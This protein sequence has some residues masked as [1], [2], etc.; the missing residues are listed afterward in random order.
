[1]HATLARFA[2]ATLVAPTIG[3]LLAPCALAQPA[4]PLEP[5]PPPFDACHLAFE[6][7]IGCGKA[8]AFDAAIAAGFTPAQ[9]SPAGGLAPRG[10]SGPTDPTNVLHNNLAIEILSVTPSGNNGT[11]E[12]S[13]SNTMTIVSNVNNLTTFTFGLRCQYTV[14]SCTVTDTVGAYA[15]TPTTLSCPVS[16]YLRTITFARPINAGET[17]TISIAY[18]GTAIPNVGLGSFFAG[19]Q[20]AV[21]TAPTV[22]ATLSEPYYAA[23]WWPCKDGDVYSLGDNS[24][25]ATLDVAITAADT[26]QSVSNGLLVGVDT[27]PGNRKTYRWHCSSP[28]SSYLVFFATSQYN[29]WSLPYNYGAGTM[30]VQFSIYPSSDTPTNRAVWEKTPA[31]LDAFAPI[32]G[33]Y[34]FLSEKYGVYQFEFS[35]G[36]EHQTYTGQGRGGAFNESIT[37]H[38]LAH[39]W[40]GDNITCKTWSDIWLNEG[41]ATYSECLWEERK[42]GS[43]GLGSL[44]SCMN[45]GNHRPTNA[46]L[47]ASNSYVYIP[48]A[49]I[50]GLS[51]SPGRIFSSSYSYRKPAWVL[52]A[53]RHVIG[54]ADFFNALQTY[55][56]AFQGSAATPADFTAIVSAVAGQDLSWFFTPWLYQPG[57]PNYTYAWTNTAINGQAYLRLSI[58]QTQ[59]S[60]APLFPMPVDVRITTTSSGTINTIVQNRSAL[61]DFLIPLPSPAA[62][63]G[64]SIDPDDWILNTGKTTGSYV[65]GPPKI[66]TLAPA[67]GESVASFA[68]P[69]TLSV[70]FSDPVAVTAADFGVTSNATSIPFTFAY[71]AGTMTATLTFA[72]PL[73]A[74][75]Y[76]VAVSDAISAVANSARL[77]GEL[78]SNSPAALPSGNGVALGS[79][80][81]TFTITAPC[82]ADFNN[83]GSLSVDDIFDFLNA[84]FAGNPAADFNGGGLAVQDIFDFLNAWFAGC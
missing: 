84:W 44:R 25:K 1:M 39:Q 23:T 16:S 36:Q 43:S 68:A 34:P 40:W 69:S 47:A 81:F 8:T 15:T 65:Q 70:G 76:N 32:Y 50:I 27:L 63:S 26:L 11:A 75:T 45:L 83:S 9:L 5:P 57:A 33:L 2:L 38:E 48:A 46:A 73:A 30:P 66:V 51:S 31:M 22:V 13:G 74:G 72:S 64:V 56:A 42:P 28:L 60:P 12:L 18:S 67:P 82:A 49:D 29:Q 14:T 6:P 3:C 20:G 21:D 55:R 54:D 24:D 77:D 79:A 53:L 71:N 80:A 37:A 41:F 19:G 62:A 10:P 58:A 17:F 59:S 35:G 4:G 52:H 61:D 7:H 78:A